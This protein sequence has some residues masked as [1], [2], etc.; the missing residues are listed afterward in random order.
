MSFSVVFLNLIRF[1]LRYIR[2]FVELPAV[3]VFGTLILFIWF[4]FT[5]SANESAREIAAFFTRYFVELPLG[6]PIDMD[7]V[8]LDISQMMKLFTIWGAAYFI[9]AEAITWLIRRLT[10]KTL[11]HSR[12][13][14]LGL[15]I[16][17][18]AGLIGLY[19][20]NR[21]TDAPIQGVINVALLLT[22]VATVSL[23]TSYAIMKLEQKLT[24]PKS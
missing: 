22:S 15:I 11:P 14:L 7:N 21:P 19:Q 8:S 10:K 16:I 1:V 6:T 23:V 3:I 13:I 20:L 24:L 4:L 18:Y 9:I 17:G 2:R 12:L 5:A